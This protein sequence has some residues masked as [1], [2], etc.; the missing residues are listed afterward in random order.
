MLTIVL[1]QLERITQ[2]NDNLSVC[3]GYGKCKDHKAYDIN[4]KF[5]NIRTKV[6]T[7]FPFFHALTGANKTSTFHRKTKLVAWEA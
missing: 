7:S 5:I 4:E 3:V 6:A 1:E 2:K